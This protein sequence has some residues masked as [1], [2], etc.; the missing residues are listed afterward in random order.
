[1]L[2]AD[3]IGNLLLGI[4]IFIST[5]TAK[6][7]TQ[8]RAQRRELRR[9]RAREELFEDHVYELRTEMARHGI[10]RPPAP[11]GLFDDPYP[12]DQ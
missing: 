6:W 5:L 1:M 9:L 3:F 4:L 11:K 8:A 10:P 2:D 12:E 7:S